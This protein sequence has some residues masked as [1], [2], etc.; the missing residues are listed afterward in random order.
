MST[1]R[2]IQVKVP[3]IGHTLVFLLCLGLQKLATG[4]ARFVFA[5]SVYQ[6]SPRGLSLSYYL[7][8]NSF[9]VAVWEGHKGRTKMQH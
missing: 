3:R 5:E 8:V 6:M 7:L 2:E 1:V 9:A 4:K